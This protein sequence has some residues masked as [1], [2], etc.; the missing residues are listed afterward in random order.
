MIL[1]DLYLSIINGKKIGTKYWDIFS[2]VSCRNSEFC[3]I[4]NGISKDIS[5][6]EHIGVLLDGTYSPEQ[7]ISPGRGKLKEI[8]HT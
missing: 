1:S 3:Q 7:I 4:V 5:N 2:T 6:I 8:K